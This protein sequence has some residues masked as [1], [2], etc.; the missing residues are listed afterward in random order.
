MKKTKGILVALVFLLT[1][2]FTRPS[3]KGF[4]EVTVGNYIIMHGF[5][6]NNKEMEEYVK[7]QKPKKK[8]IAIDRIQSLSEKYICTS[9]TQN[10]L[11][12]WEYTDG[13]EVVKRKL[14]KD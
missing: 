12:F 9:Y 2:S 6:A 3:D 11:I 14:N 8:L 1:T 13:Y 5:D 10:R 4:I 7:D